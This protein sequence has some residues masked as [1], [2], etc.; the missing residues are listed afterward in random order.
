[1]LFEMVQGEVILNGW[2]SD[3]VKD[4]LD[5]CLACKGCRGDCP[6]HVDMA[7]YKSEFL[8]H[9][10]RHHGRPR[11][12]YAFGWIHRWALLAS[13]APWL[14][15]FATQ[16]PG[17][18]RIAAWLA[19]AAPHRPIPRFAARPF[20]RSFVPRRN[21][22]VPV[23]LW[24]DTFNNYFFPGTLDAAVQVLED[25]GCRVVV[26]RAHVCCGRALYDY[27]MLGLARRLWHRTFR[28]LGPAIARGVPIVGLEPSCVAAFRDE[29]PGL[30]PGDDRARRLADSTHTLAGFLR[31][32]GYQP[33]PLAGRALLHGHCHHK[34]VLDFENERAL[35]ADMHVDLETPDSGC[36]GLAGSF[37]FELEHYK[38]AM[39]IGERV[40]LPAVRAER[41]DSLVI[42]DGF[43]CREQ[44]RHGTGRNALH[45]AEV[46]A[47]ALRALGRGRAPYRVPGP[48]GRAISPAYS[49]R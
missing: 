5:L 36:C 16:T 32:R 20:S 17:L 40:L 23:V 44:I 19:G 33:P 38:I 3:E 41:G 13:H 8:A 26:P 46:V 9:Y 43:S 27:G 6:T 12:A 47:L 11:H 4:A 1:M 25:A 35:L 42:A 15:N 45:V 14:V 22:R 48:P 37:G 18:R 24:P 21:D 34:A 28:I 29:L 2:A 39:A 49:A 10:Y 31:A 30:F 7:T